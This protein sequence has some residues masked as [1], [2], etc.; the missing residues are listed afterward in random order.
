[1]IRTLMLGAALLFAGNAIADDAPVSL[2]PGFVC[3]PDAAHRASYKMLPMGQKP[4]K[5]TIINGKQECGSSCNQNECPDDAYMANMKW[6]YGIYKSADAMSESTP[7]EKCEKEAFM[8][9]A[10]FFRDQAGSYHDMWHDEREALKNF[11]APPVNM[12][13]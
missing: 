3:D 12:G 6:A 4:Q 8:F 5:C 11:G 2:H 10:N 9:W 13:K 7:Q 1:M